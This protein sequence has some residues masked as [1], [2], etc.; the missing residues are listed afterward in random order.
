MILYFL[1]SLVF[2]IPPFYISEELTFEMEY[3]SH[4]PSI[5][6]EYPPHFASI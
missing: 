4:P 3:F 6:S 2:S 1:S 5:L